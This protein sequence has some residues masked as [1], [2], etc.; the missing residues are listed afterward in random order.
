MPARPAASNE[1]IIELLTPEAVHAWISDTAL[2]RG[3]ELVAKGRV[4]KPAVRRNLTEA[5][6]G[7]R[8][9]FRVRIT[10]D[11]E[12]F[13]PTCD[14][15]RSVRGANGPCEHVAALALLLAGSAVHASDDKVTRG[16]REP[17]ST[18][19]MERRVRVQ[20]GSTELFEVEP[21]PA[22][23]VYGKY[24]VGSPS[25]RRYE[26]E[27]RAVDA[28]QNGCSCPDFE[29]NGLGTCKHIEAVLHWCRTRSFAAV[30]RATRSGPPA[31]FVYLATDG[32]PTVA[33]RLVAN[34]SP[35]QRR[36]AARWFDGIGRA[37][38][39]VGESWSALEQDLVAAGIA[40]APEVVRFAHRVIESEQ[41]RRR[42]RKI[43]ASVR[44]AG[45]EQPGF[46]A[47]LY[48]YQVD[49]VAFLASRGRALLADDMGLG[50]TAQ[51]IAAM[52]VLRRDR[53]VR[54][55][56]VIC[57]ASL[58]H[59]W[60]AEITRFTD[61]ERS[62]IALVG[63]ARESRLAAYAS[64][65]DVLVTSYELARADQIEL[66]DIAPDL[67]VLDEAQ[68]IKNW[69]TRT[70]DAVKHIASRFA[71]V[72]TGTP[73][74]NRLDDLYSLMQVVDPHVLGPLWKFNEV[75]TR[76]DAHGKVTGYRNLDR[77]RE[78]MAPWMLRRRKDDV[79][80][81]LPEQVVNRLV[82]PMTEAQVGFH[83]DSRLSAAQLLARL[84]KRALTPAEEKRLMSAFQRMRMACN[85]AGLVDENI[86]GSPKLAELERLLDEICIDGG[87]KVVVFTEWEK[88]QVMAAGVCS[89][90]K[91]GHV[92]LHGGV[93]AASR[94]ALIE[95][96]RKDPACKVFL[97]TDA[98][99]TGL[100]LQFASHLINLDLPWNPAVLAQRIAR[101]HRIGQR[102]VA[103]VIMLVSEGS[104]EEKMEATL[105]A[106][107]ALFAAAVGDDSTTT[108]LARSTLAGRIATVLGD[109]YAAD[110]APTPLADPKGASAEPLA[111]LQATFGDSL[112]R[113]V[114]L[115][116]GRVLGVVRGQVPAGVQVP[117]IVVTENVARALEPLGNASP[118]ATG[119]ELFRATPAVVVSDAV[120]ERRARVTEAARKVAAAKALVAANLGG[121][122]LALLH[123][124]LALAC[125]AMDDR[126]DPDESPAAILASVFEHGIPSGALTDADGS[127]LT[128]AAEM[129]RAF[130]SAS[131]PSVIV[132][133]IEAEAGDL[134]A[135]A[136]A[137]VFT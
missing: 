79:L 54:R 97:S 116:D 126:G 64:D 20:R 103:N 60:V 118:I 95:R 96:F 61:I 34:A 21:H 53:R 57:P 76:I 125:R 109:A 8:K 18:L 48:P 91:L 11:G 30:G 29:T 131:P 135:R 89:K 46:R 98:G 106:K 84:K 100:N 47:K 111:A 124:A 121:E 70:A 69:R 3:H 56:L 110:T 65:F 88:F 33:L 112:E 1:T 28:H 2:E 26:V 13:V 107:R 14:C 105:S 82:V 9:R 133:R 52:M 74:E 85:A 87:H 113:V 51:A 104:F 42:V 81:Q 129:A 68:R 43:E 58:K 44:A 83:E 41:Q 119:E 23:R 50:K 130:A 16:V 127:A 101:I 17:V 66:A 24:D 7:D 90:L 32:E 4:A 136:R 108:E 40:V 12:S 137:R 19:E 114:R 5:V 123:A 128:R 117:A 71:F 27:I 122:A 25:S 120:L 63:G 102:S 31:P 36:V 99:G 39:S 93:P 72:L 6:V 115:A 15:S 55:A 75:F 67:L 77:L 35:T 45:G 37:K 94:P 132:A 73:L 62:R 49:G 92:R 134:V 38:T 10:W 80:D 59:Q 22:A 86:E 78:R